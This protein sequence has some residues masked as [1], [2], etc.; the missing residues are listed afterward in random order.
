MKQVLVVDVGNTDVVLAVFRGEDCIQRW[1]VPTETNKTAEAYGA[2]FRSLF[3]EGK[4]IFSPDDEIVLSTVVPKL[5]ATIG[6]ALQQLFSKQPLVVERSMYD[7]L[8]VKVTGRVALEIVTD[9]VDN[10]VAGYLKCKGAVIIVDFGTALSLTAVN[11]E[12]LV[13]GVA[14][15]PGLATSVAAL[16]GSTA[17]LPSISLSVP[18][19]SLGRNTVESIQSGIV[20][21]Y[22]HLVEGLVSEMKR[23][24]EKEFGSKDVKVIATGG[25]SDIIFPLT[26]VFSCQDK[27]LTL[28]GLRLIATSIV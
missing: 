10:A 3:Q 1:R 15:A 21:G 16:Y 24:L 4:F 19:S 28:K 6:T 27:D 26:H 22:K 9:L 12:G 11:H 17:Q 25:L 5:K 7:K 18:Q 13:A 2:S 20:L 8:P 23:D 14:I